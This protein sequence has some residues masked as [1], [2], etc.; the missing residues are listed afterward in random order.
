MK[1][2]IQ[3][4][5]QISVKIY[6]N[7]AELVKTLFDGYLENGQYELSWNALDDLGRQ[8]SSGVYFYVIKGQ[9]FEKLKKMT[10]I[11]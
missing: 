11:K 6:N 2:I 4:F 9:N 1:V 7:Q 3:I 5:Q 8:I 10:Y